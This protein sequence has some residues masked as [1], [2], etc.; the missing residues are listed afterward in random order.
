LVVRTA[1]R[2]CD[3][4]E[5][6]IVTGRL[7][8]GDHLDEESLSQRFGV[9]RTPIRETLTRLAASGLVELRPRR[10]AYVRRAG[11]RELVEMFEVMAELEAMCARLA[12]HRINATYRDKLKRAHDACEAAK[13][14]GDIDAYYYSNEAFH[15]IIYDSCGN[16]F[17]REQTMRLRDRLKP[18]RRLQLHVKR[19][20]ATSLQEHKRVMDAILA[21]DVAAANREVKAHIIIQGERFSDFLAT[22]P[23]SQDATNE[24]QNLEANL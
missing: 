23:D 19:R 6:D 11:I 12:A 1:D 8:P 7:K 5:Q 13:R 4:L 10:G 15:Q 22:Y 18:Y 20:V 14:S 24:N 17:L 3:E 21:G 9:S 16:S 2:I